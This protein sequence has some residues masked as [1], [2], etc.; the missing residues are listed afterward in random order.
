MESGAAGRWVFPPLE[1]VQIERIAC[2][3]PT[4]YGLHLT[5]W[6]CRSLQQVVVEQAVV[7]AIH[8]TTVARIL[9][10]ASLQPHRRRYWKT[11]AIDE[12]FTALASKVLWCYE[13]VDWLHQRGEVVIGMDEKPN[14]PALSR[15]VPRQPLQSG[16]IER[17]EFA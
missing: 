12:E 2:T 14:I 16:Q 8:Y 9:A 7:A 10:G 4:A 15:A 3:D 17:R 13:R 6:D 11:A 1:R 5:H